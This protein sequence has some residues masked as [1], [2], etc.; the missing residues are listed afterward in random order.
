MLHFP[1]TDRISSLTAAFTLRYSLQGT[2]DTRS[3]EAH[4]LSLFEANI[5]HE[6]YGK[7]IPCPKVRLNFHGFRSGCFGRS[8]GWSPCKEVN[9]QKQHTS[10]V[11]VAYPRLFR[12]SLFSTI[13]HVNLRSK[14]AFP[15]VFDLLLPRHRTPNQV[16]CHLISFC[17][18]VIDPK[19]V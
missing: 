12:R 6:N 13:S 19:N 18:S 3:L 11:S 15:H 17:K 14:A 9:R 2:R 10:T 16:C 8:V 5:P 1:L 7:Y 4:G